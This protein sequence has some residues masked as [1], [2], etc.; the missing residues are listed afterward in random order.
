LC[1][2][3]VPW[4]SLLLLEDSRGIWDGCVC[5]G[6][7]PKRRCCQFGKNDLQRAH[8]SQK[9]LFIREKHLQ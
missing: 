2:V 9:N 6:I 1:L 8:H 4:Q 5:F 7:A 3:F